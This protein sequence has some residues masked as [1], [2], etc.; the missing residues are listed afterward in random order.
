MKLIVADDSRLIRGIIEKAVSSIGFEA[1]QAGNGR[2]ALDILEAGGRDITLVL[3]DWNMPL[4]NGIDV[5]KTMR[6]DDRFKNIP[7]LMISTE[8]EDERIMDAINTGAQGYLTKPF[9]AEKLIDAIHMVLDQSRNK[10]S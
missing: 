3:M 7:V 8:S 6:G 2:E 5:L 10:I 4:L 9:T 1:V